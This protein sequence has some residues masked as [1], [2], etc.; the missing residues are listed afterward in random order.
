ENGM[1][2]SVSPYDTYCVNGHYTGGIVN[3]GADKSKSFSDD[4]LIDGSTKNL[5]Y[6][7]EQIIFNDD[8]TWENPY[9]Y[10]WMITN[11][12]SY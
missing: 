2:V 1:P 4:L 8:T 3:L 7:V 11:H 5:K 9:F 12:N 6:V 10:E